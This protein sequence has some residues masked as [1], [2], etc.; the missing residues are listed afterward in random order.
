MGQIVQDLRILTIFII[1]H[2]YRLFIIYYE[3]RPEDSDSDEVKSLVTPAVSFVCHV[4]DLVENGQMPGRE[5]SCFKV[6]YEWAIRSVVEAISVGRKRKW[7][8]L[9]ESLERVY[10][11]VLENRCSDLSISEDGIMLLINEA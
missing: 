10:R 4:L 9:V 5:L 7:N 1:L 8:S 2:A 3:K 6:Q 11:R